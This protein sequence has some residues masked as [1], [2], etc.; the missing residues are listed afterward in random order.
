VP[1]DLILFSDV[2]PGNAVDCV[3]G[4]PLRTVQTGDVD[5]GP[6]AAS[7]RIGAQ[8]RHLTGTGLRD[9]NVATAGDSEESGAGELGPYRGP[10]AWRQ[11]HGLVIGEL[12][13]HHRARGS[14]RGEESHKKAEA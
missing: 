10:K 8:D 6:G 5:K 3:E 11:G 1:V 14:G 7:T 12:L 13:I 9:K 4:E 2:E